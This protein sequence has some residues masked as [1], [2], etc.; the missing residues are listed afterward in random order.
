MVFKDNCVLVQWTKV[1]SALEGLKDLSPSHLKIDLWHFST[2]T[3]TISSSEL[4]LP[5]LRLNYDPKHKDA[6][7]FEKLLNPIILVFI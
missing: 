7:I 3:R 6:K 1:A 5:M 4:T 2:C